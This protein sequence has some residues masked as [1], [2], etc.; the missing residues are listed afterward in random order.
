MT[1]QPITDT[2]RSARKRAQSSARQRKRN[3]A[4][5]DALRAAGWSESEYRTAVITGRVQIPTKPQGEQM[6]NTIDDYEKLAKKRLATIDMLSPKCQWEK[7]AGE[8]GDDY[9]AVMRYRERYTRLMDE[10]SRA[11]REAGI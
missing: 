7:F 2:E 1:R 9:A 11:E 8:L 4:W 6:D 10:Q 5:R 3:K